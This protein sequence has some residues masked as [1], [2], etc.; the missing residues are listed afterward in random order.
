MLCQSSN[1]IVITFE[2]PNGIYIKTIFFY[3]FNK[4]HK[5]LQILLNKKKTFNKLP[6][7]KLGDN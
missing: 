1:N 4:Y 5:Y 2:K 7:L 6:V 3:L